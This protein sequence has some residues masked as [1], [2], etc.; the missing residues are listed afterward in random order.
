[1][2]PAPGIA[3]YPACRVSARAGD[4]TSRSRR[5]RDILIAGCGTGQQPIDAARRFPARARAGDRSQ[6]APASPMRSA[7]RRSSASPRSNSP[8]PTSWRSIRTGRFD[9]D[10][11]ERRAAPP[12][13]PDARAGRARSALLK[14]GGVMRLGLYSELARAGRCAWRAV[15]RGAAATTPRRTASAAAARTSIKAADPRLRPTRRARRISTASA[16]AATCCSTC[17]STG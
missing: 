16:P 13:R 4:A 6:P 12:R 17:R 14:P 9:V 8:R 1:M 10:R 7:R 11:G 2:R 3:A 5:R 15:R